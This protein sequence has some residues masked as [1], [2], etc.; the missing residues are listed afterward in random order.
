MRA[1]LGIDLGGSKI[2]GIVLDEHDQ[3]M[4]EHRVATP[5][6]DY[7]GTLSAVAALI[8]QLER[9]SGAHRLPVG[10]GTPGSVIPATGRMHNANSQCLNG[11]ALPSDLETLLERPVR[12]ANDADCLALSEQ[13]DG[14]AAHAASVF[15][16][17]L[18]T[19]VGGGIVIDGKL[20]S[21]R[22]GIA[23]EWG[24]NPLPWA[25]SDELDI[26]QCWCG[27]RGCLETW[28]SGPAM[29][30]DC[31]RRGGNALDAVEIVA[32]AGSGDRAAEVVLVAWLDRL[33]RALAQVINML[34]PQVIVVGGGLSQIERLYDEVPRQW[35]RYVFA[36]EVTTPLCRARHGDASGVRGAA[37]LW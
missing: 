34:D 36:D 28:L 6:G 17:I 14:A 26:L 21:G 13:H 9:D 25:G 24:H 7:R 2:A 30:A 3:V 19:G 23:G 10:I 31:R 27:L 18:G 1:S 11:Q 4:A 8:H 35:C 22:N 29:T 20:L 37:R 16:V 15:A 32:R 33:A 12:V 5:Q